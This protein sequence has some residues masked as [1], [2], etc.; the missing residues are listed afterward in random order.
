VHPVRDE[1]VH[2]AFE[3]AVALGDEILGFSLED[4][5]P[6][7]TLAAAELVL[8]LRIAPGLTREQLDP[9]LQDLAKA[10][11]ASHDIAEYVDSLRVKLTA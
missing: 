9:I 3:A 4:A 2:R 6:R 11:A 1:R 7:S 8:E 5:D 10:L